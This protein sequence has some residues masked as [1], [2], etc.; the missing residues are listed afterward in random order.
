[1]TFWIS[2]KGTDPEFDPHVHRD[3]WIWWTSGGSDE[4]IVR[5]ST[6]L[7]EQAWRGEL[8][9]WAG[10]PDGRL[11]L[12]TRLDQFPRDLARLSACLF[13]GWQGP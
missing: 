4:E 10:D 3:F 8:D 6:G 5:R 1:M 9:H 2:G 11:A 12:I 7:T 13:S